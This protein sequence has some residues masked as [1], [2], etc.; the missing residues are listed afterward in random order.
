MVVPLEVGWVRVVRPD[1]ARAEFITGDDLLA[2]IVP[3]PKRP[4]AS[5]SA[6]AMHSFPADENKDAFLIRGVA[7]PVEDA[8]QV[9]ALTR[10]SRQSV[11]SRRY[12]PR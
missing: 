11:D 7:E 10:R 1:L 3:S 6:I 9:E 5:R 8:P 12:R 4:I 2:F